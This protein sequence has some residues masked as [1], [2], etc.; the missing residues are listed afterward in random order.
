M[1]I[2]ALLATTLVSLLSLTPHRTYAATCHSDLSKTD[3][4]NCLLLESRYALHWSVDEKLAEITFGV[5]VDVDNAWIG[6]GL[7]ENGGMRGADIYVISP[8]REGKLG[9]RGYWAD[10]PGVP[11]LDTQQNAKIVESWTKRGAGKTTAVWKRKLNTCDPQDHPIANVTEQSV[12]WAIGSSDIFGQ[13]APENRGSSRVTFR[14]DPNVKPAVADPSDVQTFEYHFNYTVPNDKPTTYTCSHRLFALPSADTKYHIIHY[15]GLP[16]SKLVHHMIMYACIQPPARTED[17]YDCASMDQ[18]CQQYVMGWAPGQ[19]KTQLPNEAGLPVGKDGFT[20]FSLQVHYENPDLL[21]NVVDTSG[22]KISYTPT[23]RQHDLGTLFVGSTRINIP[24]NSMSHT[25]DAACPGGCTKRF[26]HPI[27]IWKNLFHMHS[28]GT[29]M[30]T[31]HISSNGT[32][33]APLGIRTHYDLNFQSQTDPIGGLRTFNPGDQLLTT[34]SYSTPSRSNATRFGESTASEMCFNI[35]QY[36][37]RIPE[38]EWCVDHG[39]VSSCTTLANFTGVGMK[40]YQ[41]LAASG[42]NL[43]TQEGLKVLAGEWVK[44]GLFVPAALGNFTKYEGKCERSGGLSGT[45]VGSG[46]AKMQGLGALVMGLVA[47]VIWTLA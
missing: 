39:G 26:P 2:S 31:R 10:G 9:V 43:D 19:G 33:L 6:F 46:A 41:E 16:Q 20:Y 3:F 27:T 17:Y 32:E 13:H 23:L 15:E 35:L 25:L 29:A 38:V 7:S 4:P 28:T 24:A 37:P 8:E 12:I 21:P 40:K 44:S 45:T 14:P 18:Y 47:A 34:C 30:Q 36:W 5:T 1:R 11:A 42:V 22:F